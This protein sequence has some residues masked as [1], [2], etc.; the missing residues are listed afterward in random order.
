[1]IE[2]VHL[3]SNRGRIYYGGSLGDFD[4][5]IKN[6]M[7]EFCDVIIWATGSGNST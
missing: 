3:Q 2:E 5:E 6:S 1:M 4:S 7:C